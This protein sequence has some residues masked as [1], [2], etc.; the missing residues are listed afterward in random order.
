M[1]LYFLIK[2]NWWQYSAATLESMRIVP[3][4]DVTLLKLGEIVF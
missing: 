2:L 1:N 4:D 3:R